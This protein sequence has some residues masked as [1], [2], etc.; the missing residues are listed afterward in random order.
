MRIKRK[1]APVQVIDPVLDRH[2]KQIRKLCKR[3]AQDIIK[4]GKLLTAAKKRV[5][6]GGWL[7]WLEKEFGWSV[8]SA[9]AFI[10]VYRFS[11]TPTF[12]KIQNMTKASPSLLAELAKQSTPEAVRTEIIQRINAG[13][14]V[15]VADVRSVPIEI[16]KSKHESRWVQITRRPT[17]IADTAV[18][19][20]EIE[21]LFKRVTNKYVVASDVAHIVESVDDRDE[22]VVQLDKLAK[23]IALLKEALSARSPLA[24]RPSRDAQ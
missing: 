15:N 19:L 8:S 17:Y 11:Q 2:A 4:I 18:I 7:N 12:A 24:I 10:R 13:E 16:V 23:F 1:R 14:R 20:N 22:F 21:G 5:K 9:E 6:H 3:T